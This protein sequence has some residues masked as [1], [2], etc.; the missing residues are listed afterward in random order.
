MNWCVNCFLGGFEDLIDWKWR[1][2]ANQKSGEL[3][4]PPLFLPLSIIGSASF[5][6]DKCFWWNHW[7]LLVEN[8]LRSVSMLENTANQHFYEPFWKCSNHWK[9]G[10]TF[11]GNIVF[12]CIA[13]IF[14]VNN[15]AGHFFRILSCDSFLWGLDIGLL[16]DSTQEKI[17]RKCEGMHRGNH[18]IKKRAEGAATL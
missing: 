3:L 11:F 13:L 5:K 2:Q 17:R 10:N 18:L 12:K 9:T 4:P 1:W 6:E 16:S 14:F 8:T 15:G 7:S